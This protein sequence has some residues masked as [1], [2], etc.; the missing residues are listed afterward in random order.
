MILPIC[1]LAATTSNA[2]P[3]EPVPTVLVKLENV[4]LPAHVQE[5]GVPVTL[6]TFVQVA[7]IFNAALTAL[8]PTVPELLGCVSQQPPAHLRE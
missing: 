3:T 1:V 7:T 6:V 2:V 5:L 4:F 8:A